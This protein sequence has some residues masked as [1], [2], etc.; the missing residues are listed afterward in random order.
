MRKRNGIKTMNIINQKLTGLLAKKYAEQY[1]EDYK[2]LENLMIEGSGTPIAQMTLSDIATEIGYG[3]VN[4][5]LHAMCDEFIFRCINE[6]LELEAQIEAQENLRQVL[7]N[8]FMSVDV[9]P[10]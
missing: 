7:D 5:V 9:R 4:E 10:Q 8:V 2:A 3:T 6:N 1:K